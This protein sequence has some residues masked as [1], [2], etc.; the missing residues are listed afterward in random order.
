MGLKV[1]MNDDDSDEPKI[2]IDASGCA[3]EIEAVMQARERM[4]KM[5]WPEATLKYGYGRI[6]L[7]T[8]SDPVLSVIELYARAST[9]HPVSAHNLVRVFGDELTTDAGVT[10]SAAARDT[11]RLAKHEDKP[12]RFMF[13][14]V[15]V[16]AFPADN[17]DELLER[18]EE[19]KKQRKKH[20]EVR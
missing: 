17:V 20:P 3:N 4:E 6:T 18:H 9:V 7:K 19:A 15:G 13:G 1:E 11:L 5:K 16:R 2:V 10:S 14:T 8:N 12:L